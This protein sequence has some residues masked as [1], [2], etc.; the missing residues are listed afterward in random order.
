MPKLFAVMGKS[1]TGKDTIFQR[2]LESSGLPLIKVIPYTTR[3]V[4]EGEREGTEYH[5]VNEDKLNE[6]SCAGRI[7]EQRSYRTVHGIWT[8]FTADDGMIDLEHNDYIMIT[9]LAGYEGLLDYFGADAVYPVY[10]EVEDGVRLSRALERERRQKEPGYAEMC[11]RFLAD[12]EDFSEESLRRLG[13][14]R[15]Y[16]NIDL[17]DCIAQIINDILKQL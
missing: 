16:Y 12:E 9:T 6:L 5:F 1:A 14:G 13:I 3:P 11:R 17:E 2:L 8:Y 15:R 7:I 10:I 4:R